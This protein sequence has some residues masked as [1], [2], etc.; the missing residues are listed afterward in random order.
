MMPASLGAFIEG[1]PP[2]SGRSTASSI[3]GGACR[4]RRICG[5][6][7]LY[8]VAALDPTRRLS[9]RHKRETAHLEAW[10][11]HATDILP[12]TMLSPSRSCDAGGWSRAIL[13]THV[14]GLGQVS[15]T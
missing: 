11:A 12:R 5:F 15:I 7:Q 1:R 3:A 8:C 4:S 9:L 6:L 13:D 14:A 2:C 10:L